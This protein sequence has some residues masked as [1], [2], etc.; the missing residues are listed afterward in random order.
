MVQAK[1]NIGIKDDVLTLK[2]IGEIDHHGAGALREEID[3]AIFKYRAATVILDLSGVS[4]MDSAGLGLILGRF[5]KTR[6]MGI[7]LIIVNPTDSIMKILLIAGA[8][9]ILDIRKV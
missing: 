4:F 2:L 6:E 1:C 9:K 7:N 5:R 3:R 8:D